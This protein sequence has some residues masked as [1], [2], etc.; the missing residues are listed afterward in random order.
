[1]LHCDGSLQPS[2]APP[3][4]SVIVPVFNME[5]YVGQCLSSL[6]KL[7]E[8][9]MEVIV[10]DDGSVDGTSEVLSSFTDPRLTVL[11]TPNGGPSAARNVGFVR[12]RGSFILP[13]DADDIAVTE[14]WKLVLATLIANPDAVVA[15][16]TLHVFEGARDDFPRSLPPSMDCPADDK[17]VPL[18]FQRNFMQMGTAIITREALAAAGGWNESLRFAEDWELWCRL[19]C[20]GRFTFCPVLMKGHRE[21]GQSA[22]GAPVSGSAR[23]PA[24]AAIEAIYR[25][26]L[27]KQRLRGDH[28]KYKRRA[29]AWQN[30]HWGTRLV[31][32]RAIWPGAKAILWSITHNLSCLSYLCAYPKRRVQAMLAS[33]DKRNQRYDRRRR[34]IKQLVPSPVL[35]LARKLKRFLHKLDYRIS[36]GDRVGTFPIASILGL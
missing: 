20:L 10:V 18:I 4:L 21:H 14:N 23:N 12:S 28:S 26:P 22:T 19:A 1:M 33:V 11:R 9:A 25:S 3:L 6:L 32:N 8:P 2:T 16:G 17:I 35:P 5:R 34:V 30:Y 31:R 36:R 13:F 7:E 29:L 15:Y 24:L 27:V